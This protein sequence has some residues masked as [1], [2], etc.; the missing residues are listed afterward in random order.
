MS[1]K[2]IF[3][4]LISTIV[5]TLSS[6]VLMEMFNA[7]TSGPILTSITKLPLQQ[8]CQYFAQESYKNNSGNGYQ[9]QAYGG[10]APSSLNGR[11]YVGINDKEVYR[12]LYANSRD[13]QS[14]INTYRDN[15]R[16][17]NILGYGLGYGGSINEGEDVLAKYYTDDMITPLNMGICYL[18]KTTLEKIFR[19]EL[20]L[21]LMNGSNDMIISNHGDDTDY[22]LF[23]GYRIYYNT[24]KITDIKYKV[25]DLFNSSDAKE[26]ESLTHID[27]ENYLSQ[28]GID[29]DD[30]RA[31]IMIAEPEFT[32]RVGYEGITPIK[33]IIAWVLNTSRNSGDDAKYVQYRREEATGPEFSGETTL[34]RVGARNEDVSALNGNNFSSTADPGTGYGV[35]DTIIYYIVR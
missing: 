31:K 2:S 22:V 17:L 26:F 1:V 35:K 29:S 18:D 14:F 25:Y 24:I 3:I 4:A 12:H 23:K 7:D 6:M 19:W 16:R 13:F 8:S 30:E 20:V 10:A 11:F 34:S 28:S 32:M 33:R 9:L 21:A 27:V 15:W 5:I